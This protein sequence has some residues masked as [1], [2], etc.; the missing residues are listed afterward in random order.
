MP[1]AT[2]SK[3]Q[4]TKVPESTMSFP[5]QVSQNQEHPSQTLFSSE[6]FQGHHFRTFGAIH[7]DHKS[8]HRWTHCKIVGAMGESIDTFGWML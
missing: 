4:V 2:P 8:K 7:M 3:Q 6:V 5:D 1:A